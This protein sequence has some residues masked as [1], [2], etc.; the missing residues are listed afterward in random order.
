MKLTI[1]RSNPLQY[2]EALKSLMVDHEHKEFAAFFDRGYADV[3]EKG[4]ASWIGFDAAG[5]VRMSVTL[6]RHDFEVGGRTLK[7][8]M[9]GNMMAAKEYRTFFP[10]VSLIK[11]L[12]KDV[13][14]DSGLDFLYTD[15]NPGAKAIVTATRLAHIGNTERYVIPMGDETLSRNIAAKAY[16]MSLR[17]RP[18]RTRGVRMTAHPSESFDPSPFF[19]PREPSTRLVPHHSRAL[20]VRRLARYPGPEY[21]WYTFSVRGSQRP[22]DAAI[23]VH[24]PASNGIATIQAVRRERTETP[25]AA[26]IPPLL[27]AMHKLR[28]QRL[29]I[30]TV[31]DSAFARELESAGFIARNDFVPIFTFPITEQGTQAIADIAEWEITSL[32]MER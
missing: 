16:T 24:G 26:L 5:G 17:L 13:E 12:L 31:R 10:M 4:G 1:R 20:Y 6:F 28:A 14:S 21:R 11:Q 32:D 8:G 9:L 2:E 22:A 19:I 3:V 7:A 30:E 18:R 25:I 29:Q 23:L 15:P 27:G